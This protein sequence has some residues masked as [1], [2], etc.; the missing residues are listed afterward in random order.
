MVIPSLL[1]MTFYLLASLAALRHLLGAQSA[2]WVLFSLA[3]SAI[4]LHA[5][6]LAQETMALERAQNL[7]LLNVASA[8]SLLIAALMSLSVRRFNGWILLPVAYGFAALLQIASSV[9]PTRYLIHL[10]QRP[11]L[12]V[13]IA[14]ALLAFSLL[15]MASLFSLLLAYLNHYLKIRKRL[16]L[17]PHLPPLLTVEQRIY[18]LIQLGFLLLTL[19][20]LCGWFFIDEMFAPEQ[21]LKAVLTFVAWALYAVLLWGH[22]RHGWR[23]RLL[24][25]LSLS[26]SLLLVLAY[27]GSRFLNEFWLG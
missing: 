24:I 3:W 10:E 7:S 25:L 23:G 4:A 9:M 14:L 17:L 15:M 8:V 5:A 1:C 22:Y 27:F 21:R 2:S 18:Q 26:G 16:G 12:M 13:H 11:E 20:I 19:S 6:G